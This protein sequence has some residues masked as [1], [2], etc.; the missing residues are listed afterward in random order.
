MLLKQTLISPVD[1]QHTSC[2]KHIFQMHHKTANSQF[3]AEE[4]KSSGTIKSNTQI[5]SLHSDRDTVHVFSALLRNMQLYD[6]LKHKQKNHNL[7]SLFGIYLVNCGS[8]TNI[9]GSFEAINGIF[10]C[11]QVL[12]FQQSTNSRISLL[13]Q[14]R[15]KTR[16]YSP[17]WSWNLN[18]LPQMIR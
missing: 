9:W 7:K 5:S 14:S 2:I 1:W 11:S 10:V 13:S 3:W 16:K 4:L 15:K 17:L 6:Q 8:L 12:T 18:F